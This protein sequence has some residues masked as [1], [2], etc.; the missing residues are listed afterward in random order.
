MNEE[1]LQAILDLCI[2]QPDKASKP[3]QEL[4]ELFPE[5]REEITSLMQLVQ[6]LAEAL[7]P[8]RAPSPFRENLF[9]S[10]LA[11]ARE[12]QMEAASSRRRL[13]SPWAL[14]LAA[15]ASAASVLVGVITYQLWSRMRAHPEPL[16][17][18]AG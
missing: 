12:Q 11:A 14:G 10:L 15:A 16:S 4:L 7:V 8:L 2:R 3:L 17:G 18:P 6:Q 1:L 13:T 5:E 9:D